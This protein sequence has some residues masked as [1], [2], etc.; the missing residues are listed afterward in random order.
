MK[1][2]LS[3]VCGLMVSIGLMVLLAPA[4]DASLTDKNLKEI[5]C[6]D[7]KHYKCYRKIQCT[8]Y[9]QFYILNSDGELTEK[10]QK[11]VIDPS[12]VYEDEAGDCG[13]KG[14]MVRGVC[15][16][17]LSYCE[18]TYGI[19]AKFNEYKDKCECEE[20]YEMREN[21]KGILKCLK[22]ID[23]VKEDK[24]IDIQA[25]IDRIIKLIDKLQKELAALKS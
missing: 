10:C 9:K 1:K 25:E 23:T 12:V 3:I 19:Q 16:D 6:F 2:I 24:K 13:D 5:D 14:V 17:G 8:W 22:P 11:P 15:R 20:K 4:V 21:D 18:D 7:I